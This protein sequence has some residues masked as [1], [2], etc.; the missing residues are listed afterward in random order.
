MAL[1]DIVDT[2]YKAIKDRV[3]VVN[4]N[5]R[6][7]GLVQVS[8]WPPETVQEEA[9]YLLLF[10]PKPVKEMISRA[11][12]TYTRMVQWTWLV[13]GTDLQPGEEGSN[14]GDRYDLHEKIVEELIQAHAVQAAE[15]KS[16]SLDAND[17]LVGATSDP[18]QFVRWSVPDFGSDYNKDTGLVYGLATVYVS[19]IAS[20]IS[21]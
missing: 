18:A 17:L 1:R 20:T 14:R 7:E 8:A 3:R 21:Q 15:K 10:D 9:L 4:A 11:T 5:R 16:W 13:Q 2:Y 12:P 6:F 19:G